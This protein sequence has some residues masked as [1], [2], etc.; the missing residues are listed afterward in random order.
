MRKTVGIYNHGKQWDVFVQL[1][2]RDIRYALC[3]YLALET[4]LRISDIL[5]LK[6][7]IKPIFT[8]REGKTGKAR[9][10]KLSSDLCAMLE[11]YDQ[12]VPHEFGTDRMFNF[13]RS[14][15]WRHMKAATEA[16]G[17]KRVGVHGLRKTY[18]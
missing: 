12:L 7:P 8:V 15:F 9:H 11:A 13:C 3:Y 17:L 4:G 14:T 16:C 5:A 18:G 6:R 2:R 1:A 10:I